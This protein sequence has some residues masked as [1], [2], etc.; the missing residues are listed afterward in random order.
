VALDAKTGKIVW[1]TKNGDPKLG[2]TSTNAPL[3]VKD[4]V[5]TGI[6]G[7]EFGVRGFLAAYNIKDGSLAWKKYSMGPDEDVG[8]DPE[9]TMTWTDGKMAPVG[10]K[11]QPQDLAG[12]SVEN[13]RWHHLGLVQL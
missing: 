1:K 12:G 4:K 2:M 13:R 5:L 3:V 6:A 10:K 7:G 8:L 9:K 11:L